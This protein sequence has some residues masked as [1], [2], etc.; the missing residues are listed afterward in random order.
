MVRLLHLRDA[1]A[2]LRRAVL[3]A[4]NDTAALLSSFATYAAGFLVRPFGA[5]V[6]GRIGDLVGRKYTFLVTIVM[7]G[8]LDRA[9]GLLPD[10]ATIGMAAPVMLVLLRCCR[11]SRS[12]GEYGGAATYVAEHAPDDKRG[13][14]HQLDSD[15]GDARVLPVAGRHS[16]SCRTRMSRADFKAGA[17]AFRSWCRSILLVVSVYIRLR[18]KE[19]PVFAQMKA[20]G[21]DLKAPLTESFGELEATEDRP[22]RALRRDRG[23]G[24]VW[25][26]G[27]FYALFFLQTR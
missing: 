23:Q 21:K 14:L 11:A 6:F 27:Q 7:H 3:S 12:G 4:G 9:V 13:L 19:S 5:L 20:E 2:V 8:R 17:G 22:A 15:H 18:L 10:V 24:V 16:G 1:R 26:T 25:Y